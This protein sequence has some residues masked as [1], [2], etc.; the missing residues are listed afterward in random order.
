[1]TTNDPF[2]KLAEISGKGD[3]EAMH[4]LLEC[5]M[6]EEEARLVVELPISS[7]E[8]AAKFNMDEIAVEERLLN[9]AQRG[10][11]APKEDEIFHFNQIPAILH[12]NMFSSAPEHIPDGLDKAWKSMYDG[13]KY[14]KDLSEMYDGFQ[15]PIL[16]V[17]PAERSISTEIQLLPQESITKIIE[18]HQDLISVRNC[19][20]RNSFKK[21]HHPL[22]VCTQFGARAEYD[23]FRGSGRK[24]SADEAV[25][26]GLTGVGAGLIPTVTNI[27]L[28]ENLE[29]I[30]YCCGCAC[31]VLD[32]ALKGGN[33]SKVLSPSRFEA[34]INYEACNGC[35]HC[36][37]RCQV[38]A[39]EMKPIP[40]HDTI[41]AVLDPDKCVGCG[42]CDLAC[43][44]GAITMELVRQPEFIPESI[45]DESIVHL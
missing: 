25:S 1:M 19:C 4:R 18:A 44:P 21:C 5:A 39:I 38:G 23:L 37:P 16:R 29:F 34:K 7:K 12:D 24:V 9:L 17:I 31:L 6:S 40:G 30:C 15:A 8:L 32:P 35:K 28:T 3:S 14:W 41:K 20:C 43:N 2:H 10:I 13:E 22:D 27:S 26:I 45:A 42:V 33:I 36:V 11:V